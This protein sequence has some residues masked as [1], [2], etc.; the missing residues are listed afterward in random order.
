MKTGLIISAALCAIHAQT[1][2]QTVTYDTIAKT[3]DQAVGAPGSAFFATTAF[4]A[5]NETGG[6]V[7]VANLVGPGYNA[8][9]N[10]TIWA[11]DAGD[12]LRLVA[13][14]GDQAP[15]APA[16]VVF[17]DLVAGDPFENERRPELGDDGTGRAVG[18]AAPN[19]DFDGFSSLH[20]NEAGEITFVARLAGPTVDATNGAALFTEAGGTGLQLAARTGEAAPVDGS[21]DPYTSFASASSIADGTV[22][23]IAGIGDNSTGVFSG[24]A[25][26]FFGIDAVATTNDTPPGVFIPGSTFS[27]FD[28]FP[29]LTA[30]GEVC[31]LAMYDD[32]LDPFASSDASGL[33]TTGRGPGLSLI[34]R[35]DQPTPDVPEAPPL[36]FLQTPAFND[37]TQSA[38]SGFYFTQ[39][40]QSD[41][42]AWAERDGFDFEVVF[43]DLEPSLGA[44]PNDI[45]LQGFIGSINNNA[46]VVLFGSIADSDEE[47]GFGARQTAW[48]TQDD[49]LP[50]VVITR[51][52]E[53]DVSNGTGTPDSRTVSGFFP[54]GS[55]FDGTPERPDTSFSNA[56]LV[57]NVNFS[58][59]A[60]AVAIITLDADTGGCPADFDNDGDV[61]LGDFGAFGIDFNRSD[62]DPATNPCNGD[63]N[64]DGDVDLGDFG[65]FGSVF[66]TDL[67]GC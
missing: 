53:I 5:I 3:G 44:G 59:C 6:V 16:G 55:A 4:P 63:F 54:R 26:Q 28:P 29:Y 12:D 56:G 49:G 61:D 34:I 31:F 19:S 42:L 2:A 47:V 57:T 37:Q 24:S 1:V 30:S 32:P 50:R 46:Q 43:D 58:D 38:F 52:T 25:I 20:V 40:F 17:A 62:C 41:S 14:E 18:P 13:R 60:F 36:L 7:F 65:F 15:G 45:D 33:W 51:G 48:I 23:F 11:R 22:L 27:S 10:E 67:S 9:N 35:E 39:T 66:S 21:V 64:G 8:S